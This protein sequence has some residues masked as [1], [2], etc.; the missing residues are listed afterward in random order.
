MLILGAPRLRFALSVEDYQFPGMVG[1]PGDFDPEWLRIHGRFECENGTW[2]FSDPC[3]L[4]S[5]LTSLAEWLREVPVGG[6]KRELSF[7]EPNI[8][9]EHVEGI[10]G[11]ELYV[12]FS[13]EASP[14][15][16]T[17]EEKVGNGVSICIPFADINFSVAADSVESMCKSFPEKAPRHDA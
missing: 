16:A 13:Q 12:W 4:T 8:R 5:E 15:W 6:P 1:A 3:L 9:F 17:W 14:P 11:D 7:L 2:E 10:E